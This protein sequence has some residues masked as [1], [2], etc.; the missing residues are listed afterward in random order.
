MYA[1]IDSGTT[2]TRIF[3]SDDSNKIVVSGSKKIGV[4]DTSITGTRDKLKNS[5]SSLFYD[6]LEKNEIDEKQ[7]KFAIAF[8]MITSEIG[9]IEIPHII[10]PVGVKELSDG[11]VEVHSND[12]L[13]ISRPVYFIPGIRNNNSKDDWIHNLR[14]IDFM[15]GEEVQL[16]GVI[17]LKKVTQP[18]NIVSLSSH[19]KISH[20]DSNQRVINSMTTLSGQLY[21][22]ITTSTNIGKSVQI[23]ENERENKYKQ[24]EVIEAAR[25]CVEKAGLG[26]ALLMPRLMETLLDTNA[27][28]RI[29]FL[30]AAIAADDMK[31]FDEM[32]SMGC[33]AKHYVLYGHKS[34]CYLYEK[35]IHQKYGENIV[36]ES[37][38]E[39]EEVESLS[40][41]GILLIA[42]EIIKKNNL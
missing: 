23:L 4:R 8:G 30:N 39:K 1:I 37:I 18:C 41:R 19:T 11:I 25:M 36:V 21:E 2:N 3:I 29:W 27:Q 40:I 16:I 7:V 10:A 12:V 24:Q 6:I 38:Y 14:F 35:M 26:R 13:P 5:V 22:A 20:I 33:G 28:E 9:L 17:D 31:T 42:Q 32:I 34:R 15:R